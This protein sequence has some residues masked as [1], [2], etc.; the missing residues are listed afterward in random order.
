MEC[1]KKATYL[2]RE[3]VWARSCRSRPGASFCVEIF[4]RVLNFIVLYPCFSCFRLV[5]AHYQQVWHFQCALGYESKCTPVLRATAV[6]CSCLKA[7]VNPWACDVLSM[8]LFISDDSFMSALFSA[9]VCLF[10]C[11]H[12][13]TLLTHPINYERIRVVRSTKVPE[14]NETSNRDVCPCTVWVLHRKQ[15]C[16]L[17][18]CVRSCRFGLLTGEWGRWACGKPG[19]L[20]PKPPCAT[21]SQPVFL[22]KFVIETITHKYVAQ[23]GL[24]LLHRLL[25]QIILK[26]CL[27]LHWDLLQDSSLLLCH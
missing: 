8:M 18:E 12:R 13:H 1:Q 22:R 17:I 10:V 27:Q 4:V 7:C 25:G 9:P 20:S 15:Y 26:R 16:G 5:S 3:V 2:C 23:Y 19:A 21:R 6:L 24:F 14:T 11:W